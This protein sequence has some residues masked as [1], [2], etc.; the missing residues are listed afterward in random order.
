MS[1]LLEFDPT[2]IEVPVKIG[3]THY[4][5]READENAA[6]VFRNAAVRGA[7][8]NDGKVVGIDGV[9]DIQSLLLSLCLFEKLP[10]GEPKNIPVLLQVVRSWPSRIVK[11]LFDKAKEISQLDEKPATVDSVKKQIADLTMQLQALERR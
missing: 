7:K 10:T 6:R 2:L 11:P 4:V 5:L 3:T 1:D 9:G 8:M